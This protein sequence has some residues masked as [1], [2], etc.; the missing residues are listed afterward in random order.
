MALLAVWKGRAPPWRRQLGRR[1]HFDER[2]LPTGLG[3]DSEMTR[4]VVCGGQSNGWLWGSSCHNLMMTGSRRL[5]MGSGAGYRGG[6]KIQLL[7][8]EARN[9]NEIVKE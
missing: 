6:W 4:V 9:R 8:V 2:I 1:C 5:T 3:Y 7:R